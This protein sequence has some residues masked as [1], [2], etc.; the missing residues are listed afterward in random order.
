[1]IL[2]KFNHQAGQEDP[3]LN[4]NYCAVQMRKDMNSHAQPI[5]FLGKNVFF[6]VGKNVNGNFCATEEA[7]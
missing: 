4:L 5:L 7:T 6:R 1:M 2:L 3:L